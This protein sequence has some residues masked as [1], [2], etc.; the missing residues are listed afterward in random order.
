MARSRPKDAP[1]PVMRCDLLPSNMTAG[2]EAKVRD[3]LVAYRCSSRRRRS[4]R[5]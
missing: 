4:S 5:N 2:K 1:S 3:L